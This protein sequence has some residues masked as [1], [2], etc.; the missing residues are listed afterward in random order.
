[1]TAAALMA[2]G[3]ASTRH[4]EKSLSREEISTTVSESRDTLKSGLSTDAM[5]KISGLRG[6]LTTRLVTAAGIAEESAR[7]GLPIRNL[8]DLPEGAGYVSRQGRAGIELR[9]N[10]DNI[11]VTGHCDSI[12]RLYMYYLNESMEQTLE[13]D[14]LHRE[15]AWQRE[16]SDA[17]AAELRTLQEKAD[18]KTDRPSQTCHWWTIAGFAAGL[19][20]ASP[21]RKLINRIKTFLKR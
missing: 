21:A 5:T 3:C 12:N 6:Q 8:L 17:R 7:L 19:L 11:E 16:I 10:G 20:C 2:A 15:L 9:R 14:S 18:E 13:I 4:G 1:M